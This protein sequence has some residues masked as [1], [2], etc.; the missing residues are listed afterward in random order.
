MI[1]KL[2]GGTRVRQLWT[3]NFEKLV[4]DWNPSQTETIEPMSVRGPQYLI[5]VARDC[6]RQIQLDCV[7]SRANRFWKLSEKGKWELQPVDQNDR[8]EEALK[9][10]FLR[11]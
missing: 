5:C 8:L 3:E 1:V 6:E 2:F 9:S 7:S 10:S 4:L 11:S